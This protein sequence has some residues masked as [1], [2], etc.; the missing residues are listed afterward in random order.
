MDA[1]RIKEG[2]RENGFSLSLIADAL[3][4]SPSLVSKVVKRQAKSLE[5]AKAI[6]R[7]LDK[8]VSEV[9]PDVPEYGKRLVPSKR[10]KVEYQETLNRLKKVINTED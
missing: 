6:S 1:E 7:A 9:F 5:V 10:D 4:R 2:L 8:Q 3:G